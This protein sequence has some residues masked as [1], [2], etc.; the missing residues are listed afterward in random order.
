[1]GGVEVRCPQ[2]GLLVITNHP[3]CPRYVDEPAFVPADSRPRYDRLHELLGGARKVNVE[4]VKQALRDHQGLVCSHGAH[5]PK[6]RFGT[7]WSAVGRPGERWLDIAAGNPC[8]T[9]CER[10]TF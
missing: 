2:D 6:R 10:R 7:L 3:L 8:T 4:A 1:M 9:K 5:F